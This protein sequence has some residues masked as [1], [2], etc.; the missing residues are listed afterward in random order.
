MKLFFRTSIKGAL[1]GGGVAIALSAATL[2]GGCFGPGLEERPVSELVEMLQGEEESDAISAASALRQK[3]DPAAIDPLIDAATNSEFASVRRQSTMALQ[4]FDA[5][6]AI[7]AL[8]IL[9][10]DGDGEIAGAAQQGLKFAVGQSY[11]AIGAGMA[12]AKEENPDAYETAFTV[13]KGMMDS[14]EEFEVSNAI[15]ALGQ[16]GDPRAGALL[17]EKMDTATDYQKGKL[18]TALGKIDS[19][20]SVAALKTAAADDNS[21]VAKAA[22]TALRSLGYVDLDLLKAELETLGT[23]PGAIATLGKMDT[24]ESLQLLKAQLESPSGDRKQVIQALGNRS[25][26]EAIEALFNFMRGKGLRS[27][28]VISTLQLIGNVGKRSQDPQV[29]KAI[30]NAYRTNDLPKGAVVSALG[31]IGDAAYGPAQGLLSHP[32]PKM[33][34]LGVAVLGVIGKEDAIAPL[35][36]KLTDWEVA[37]AAGTSLKQLGWEPTKDREKVLMWLAARDKAQLTA[38]WDTTKTVLLS[39]AGSGNVD[40]VANAL[41]GFLGIGN[42]SVIPDLKQNLNAR[43]NKDIALVYLNC[44]Q[45]ELEAAA[46][47]WAKRNGYQVIKTPGVSNSR[48][49]GSL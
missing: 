29:P 15:T 1:T 37:P 3:G 19:P 35:T 8:V 14:P 21:V 30:I 46:Q 28:E 6:K 5:P 36:A 16:T 18:V 27:P 47:D 12:A 20:E 11:Q 32:E 40:A 44:G 23:R 41:Y 42:A 26:P 7:A 43:G 9:M 24:P 39:E 22:S 13:L 4:W 38:N 10:E 33:E 48:K 31:T 17:V 2:L 34:E 49:W 45:P 25:E